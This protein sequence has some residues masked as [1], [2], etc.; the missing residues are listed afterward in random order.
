MSRE[1][2]LDADTHQT[3]QSRDAEALRAGSL[4]TMSPCGLSDGRDRIRFQ[5]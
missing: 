2:G 4:V 1:T 5:G 3:E